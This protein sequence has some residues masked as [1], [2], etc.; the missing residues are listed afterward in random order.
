MRRS[1]NKD[2]QTQFYLAVQRAVQNATGGQKNKLD[3]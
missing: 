1:I 2:R 3:N